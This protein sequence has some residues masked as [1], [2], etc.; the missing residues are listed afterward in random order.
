MH[1]PSDPMFVVLGAI[2][3]IDANFYAG[4]AAEHPDLVAAMVQ[5]SAI[6]NL[7]EAIRESGSAIHYGLDTIANALPTTPAN[8]SNRYPPG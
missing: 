4:Y 8:S 6:R 3:A 7:A 2:K 5:A 1:D